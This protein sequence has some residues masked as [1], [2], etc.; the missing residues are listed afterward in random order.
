MM[1][2]HQLGSIRVTLTRK[3]NQYSFKTLLC[4]NIYFLGSRRMAIR[5]LHVKHAAFAVEIVPTSKAKEFVHAAPQKNYEKCLS[6]PRV[7]SAAKF[8]H[9]KPFHL[10]R[11]MPPRNLAFGA[12]DLTVFGT[13]SVH[14]S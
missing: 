12:V 4:E 7:G 9:L 13:S 11:G 6:F 5:T 8:T 1:Q 10:H 3:L 2:T 14:S